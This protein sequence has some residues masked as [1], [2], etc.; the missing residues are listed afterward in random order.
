[1]FLKGLNLRLKFIAGLVLFA[2]GLGLCITVIIYFHLNSVMRSE[3]SQRS[4]L[5]LA[6]SN[7]V[8]DYVKAQL[9]PEMFKVLPNGRFVL[10][11]MSSS[12]ISRQIMAGLNTRDARRY[13]YRRVSIRP[14][15]P[16]SAPNTFE[17]GLIQMFDRDKAI[18]TW[19][20]DTLVGTKK[21]HLIARPVTFTKSCMQCHGNPDDAPSELIRI[22]GGKNGFFYRPG[23][24]GGVVV[25]GFPVD[26]I[27]GPVMDVTLNYLGFYLLGI[28]LF[29]GLIS[30]FFDR[31]VMKNLHE[32]THIFKNCF[33]GT[34]E[35]EI[36]NSLSRKDEIEGLIEGVG[37]L[38]LCLARARN[39]LED[40]A[41]N[42]EK[43]VEERTR[44]LNIEAEKHLSDVRLF[45]DML[46]GFTSL[47]NAGQLIP[48][49]L[50]NVGNRFEARQVVY[51]CTAVSDNFY[52]WKHDREVTRINSRIRQL[53]WK[54]EVM[55]E[56]NSLYIPIKSPDTHW[57]ILCISW[58]SSPDPEEF[59]PV[60]LLA[61]G[62]QMAILIENIKAF[63]DIR[64]QNDTLQSIFEGISD[65]LLLIDSDGHIIIA[66]EAG[67]YLLGNKA[68]QQQEENLKKFLCR[69][70]LSDS[71]CNILDQVIALKKPLAKEIRTSD[72]RYFAI[73]LYPLPCRERSNLRIV[74]YTR[75]ITMEKQM[76][77][78]MQ[79]T[80]R[81]S[82]IG[83]MAAGIAHEINNPLGVIQCYADLVK[84]A[85]DDKKVHKDIEVISK[86]TR[87]VQKVI[88]NLL[89]LARPKQVITGK[90]NVNE[91]VANELEVFRTQAAS[92][93]ITIS[94]DL[95]ENL[96]DIKCDAAILE[97]I[98]TNLW[99]NAFDSTGENGKGSIHIA[100]A[101]SSGG[102][103]VLSME[104]DGPGIPEDIITNIFDP[105]YT[106][107]EVGKGTGLGLSVIYGFVSE[108]GG[109]I[110]VKS[111]DTTRFD[112]SFPVI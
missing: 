112:I 19:E 96:P 69:K 18:K 111:N 14:R 39:K 51:H 2:L 104:D 66:N 103:V 72:N 87:S 61:L 95:A 32:L 82:A 15:N 16:D 105:F 24:V 6:L 52:V 5:V 55:F 43:R 60:V 80:E 86:H 102:M 81:L 27:K 8:Q 7:A 70:S 22:Y 45:V 71:A 93:N 94:S 74:V 99:L 90:C 77:E 4:R 108:L 35:Q 30:L 88:Q 83:K 36:I 97:Q 34:Q 64:L 65:P 9:R 1:M 85:V 21:Y 44:K 3:I 107:K 62:Q 29:A 31:L 53:L 41:Q 28:M 68:R 48:A 75:E 26:T 98:L 25:A 73:D 13:Y 101:L 89:D 17:T 100:T 37:E 67:K 11:A 106:T 58:K 46:A 12:Y 50:E 91:V 23:Q 78:K 54:D 79:Q 84:D 63:S 59:D 20:N 47:E 76:K 109:E 38:A 57:G 10:K 110:N 40:Y 92:K 33:S 49:V 42:L 56:K